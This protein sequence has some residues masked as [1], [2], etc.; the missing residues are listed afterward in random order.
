M[1][2]ANDTID[3]ARRLLDDPVAGP[4]SAAP[5]LGAALL[6]AVAAVMMASVVIMGP[7][8]EISEPAT[9]LWPSA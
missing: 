6:A 9:P 2:E 1:I 8:V 5:T 4:A 3:R 7:T